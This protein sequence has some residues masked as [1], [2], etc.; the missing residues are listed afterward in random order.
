MWCALSG[1]IGA[2]DSLSVGTAQELENISMS[3]KTA[4]VW[5]IPLS[6]ADFKAKS[7]ALLCSWSKNS[8]RCLLTLEKQ[9]WYRSLGRQIY[10]YEEVREE[11]CWSIPSYF[12]IP[13]PG[14]NVA[15]WRRHSYAKF[16]KEKLDHVLCV[17][18]WNC[19][20]EFIK[21][22]RKVVQAGEMVILFVFSGFV[23]L[24]ASCAS[25]A[26]THNQL[27]VPVKILLLDFFESTCEAEIHR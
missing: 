23:C 2:C 15:S 11:Y 5:H 12:T 6:S 17:A 24:S 14:L 19:L 10:E 7:A 8:T 26:L 13:S 20:P 16:T 21:P 9:H 27:S 3:F 4:T 22:E 25:Q 1:F 18:V